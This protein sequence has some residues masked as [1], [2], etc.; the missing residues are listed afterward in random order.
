[1]TKERLEEKRLEAIH[2][3]IS[4]GKHVLQ[5]QQTRER[6]LREMESIRQEEPAPMASKVHRIR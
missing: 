6:H 5:V 1:M 3:L 2:W 4:R